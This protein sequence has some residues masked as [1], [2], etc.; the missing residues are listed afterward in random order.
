MHLH[1]SD[2][3]HVSEATRFSGCSKYM[4]FVILLQV[5]KV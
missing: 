5:Y 2:A 1:V 4:V 3:I